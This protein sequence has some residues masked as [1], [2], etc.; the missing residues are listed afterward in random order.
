LQEF[1]ITITDN[2]ERENAIVEFCYR[3]TND[4]DSIHVKYSS[5]NEHLFSLSTN[6]LWFAEISNYLVARKISAH[7]SLK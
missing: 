1:D 3:L 7:L 5:P 4:G 6:T 2:L